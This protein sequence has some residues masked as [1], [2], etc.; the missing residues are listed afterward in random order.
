MIYSI[1]NKDELKHLEEIKVLLTKVNQVR[2]IGILSKQGFH[3]DVEEIFEPITK[4][5]M[6]SSQIF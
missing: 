5:V 4:K 2:L 1:K 3:R 6:D